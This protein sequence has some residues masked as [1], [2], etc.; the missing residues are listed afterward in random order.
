MVPFTLSFF[1]CA[2]R[3][4][5]LWNGVPTKK[6]AKKKPSTV[7]YHHTAEYDVTSIKYSLE[8]DDKPI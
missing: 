1:L 6:P 4:A 3:S 5:L 7:P 2:L 8:R